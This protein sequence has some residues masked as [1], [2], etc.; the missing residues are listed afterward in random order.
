MNITLTQE[1]YE[2]LIF[3]ARQGAQAEG[4]NKVRDLEQW[5]VLI[6]K[7][8]GITRSLV[9]VQW[10]ELG[11]ALPIGTFFPHKWPPDLRATIEYVTRP[12]ARADVDRLLASR[13]RKPLKVLCTKDPAGIVG[14]TPVEDFFPK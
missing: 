9:L 11:Q 1:Q 14:W 8:N 12:V 10:E 3:L 6:E 4:E 2:S 13:A 5:L 7:A